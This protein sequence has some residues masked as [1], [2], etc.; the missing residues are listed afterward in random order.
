M[1][2]FHPLPPLNWPELD[3]LPAFVLLETNKFD[4]DNFRSYLFIEPAHQVQAWRPAEIEPALER[5][6]TYCDSAYVAG[7]LAYE[8]SFGWHGLR[9]SQTHAGNMPLL[10]FGVFGKAIV[11]DH[12]TGRFNREAAGL[13]RATGATDSHTVDDVRFDISRS[14]YRNRIGHIKRRIEAG[15]T[16]QVNFTSGYKFKL[17]GSPFSLYE[18]LKRNQRVAYN[19][20]LKLDGRYVM[21]LSPEL[22]FR[23]QGR[24]VTARPMKG[25]MARG[26]T[27]AEDAARATLLQ[28]DE[29]NRS[30]NVMIV[31]L[32]RNDLGRICETGTVQTPSLFE[33]E[34]Y[35]TLFQMTSTVTGELRPGVRWPEMFKCL[36]PCGSVTGAPK[37]RTMHII[38]QLEDRPRGVYTGAI[39]FIAP[40]GDACFNVPIRT[41]TIEGKQAE[42]GVGSGIVYDSDADDEYDECRLKADF[43]TAGSAPFSLI[44]TLLWHD[45]YKR[46]EG[47]M[48]RLRDSAF[49]FGFPF[50]EKMIRAE[51]ASI[52]GTLC[53][54]KPHRVR[55]LLAADGSVSHSLGEI[56]QPP[57]GVPKV[58]LSSINTDSADRFLFHKTT[59]RGLYDDAYRT[60]TALG[61]FDV[62]FF[63]ER[64]ELT[65]GAISNVFICKDGV[66]ATPPQSCG[67]LAGIFRAEFLYTET[68]AEERVLRIEDLRTADAVYLTNSV[69][70]MTRVRVAFP[71]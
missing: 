35:D 68:R 6:N 55:L 15:D 41:V 13:V 31:D 65:E 24:T 23:K 2:D 47:H 62:L 49:Y 17:S 45:G 22:F 30:E 8:A 16:Y 19:A 28:Q 43:L 38:Q 26:R 5:L 64:G 54:G 53:S 29:K 3:A 21:S 57:A 12:R 46:L 34:R 48:S 69:R 11:F 20:L 59:R 52:A 25:T 10:W 44:E 67:L 60:H 4:D 9:S 14:D 40:D 27:T 37:R 51:M 42:M 63:N 71:E 61:F 33:I 32:M 39:G 7:F 1:S 56:E 70:G 58:A 50:D 66:Y 18:S 36:F